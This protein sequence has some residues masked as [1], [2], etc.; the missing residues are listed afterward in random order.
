MKWIV[1]DAYANGYVRLWQIVLQ[2]SAIVGF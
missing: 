1:S 2:N